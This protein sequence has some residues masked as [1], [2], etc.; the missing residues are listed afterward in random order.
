MDAYCAE[1]RKLEKHFQGLEILY[2]LRDS[3]VATD[4]LGKLRSDRTK[5]PPGVFVELLAPSIKQPGKITPELPAPSTQVLVIA[6]SWTQIFIDYIK[7]NKL[8]AD[9]EDATRI[10]QRSKNLY[11]S[12]RQTLQV[13]RIIRSTTQM[14]HSR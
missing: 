2:V 6:P 14:H 4:I 11:P 3:N 1:V 5:V 9:K 12:G 13:G 10:I 7:E 8:P